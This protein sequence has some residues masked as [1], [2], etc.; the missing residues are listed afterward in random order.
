MTLIS[1]TTQDRQGCLVAP[2][3]HKTGSEGE[4]TRRAS[5]ALA[6]PAPARSARR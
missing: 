1:D 5:R 3:I 4:T 6:R 2:F